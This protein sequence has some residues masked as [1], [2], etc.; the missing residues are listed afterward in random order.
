MQCEVCGR[1]NARQYHTD[2]PSEHHI[3]LME[4]EGFALFCCPACMR[5]ISSAAVNFPKRATLAC[6]ELKGA[7]LSSAVEGTGLF[8]IEK[9]FELVDKMTF[10]AREARM[11]MHGY[12]RSLIQYPMNQESEE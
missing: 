3:R 5:K 12:L 7:I 4:V 9:A 2:D 1:R 6:L 10:E 11:E 8:E